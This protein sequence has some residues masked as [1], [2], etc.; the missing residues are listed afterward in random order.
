VLT[1][2]SDISDI[3]ALTGRQECETEVFGTGN[4]RL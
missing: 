4:V 3:T 1:A 2:I